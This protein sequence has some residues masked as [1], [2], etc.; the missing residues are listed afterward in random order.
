MI[1]W[2][3]VGMVSS[4]R[5]PKPVVS[6]GTSR[7]PSSDCPSTCTKRSKCCT[8]MARAFSLRGRKHMATP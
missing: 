3:I 4:T 7:Q 2:R 6:I 1:A 5:S 8:A